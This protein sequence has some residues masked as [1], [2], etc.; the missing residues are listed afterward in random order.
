MV[1]VLHRAE[2][3]DRLA[4]GLAALLATPPAD[5]FAP[6]LVLVPAKGV[7]RWLSQRLSHRLGAAPGGTDGV[8]AGVEFRN[9]AALIAEISG[10]GDDDPW[11]AAALSWP[12]LEVLDGCLAEPWAAVLARH[13]GR[14]DEDRTDRAGRRYALARR[15]AALFTTY[16]VSRP[17]VVE[18]WLAGRD[19]DGLGDPVPADLAWQPEL[20]RRV[21][22]LVPGPAPPSGM[23][24]RWRG[25]AP[26]RPRPVCR[27]GS[28][29]SG[30][31]G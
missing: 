9:P 16:A 13:L 19:T 29:C 21:S 7:E 30:T 1:V 23:P 25:C 17:Q 14:D 2:R 20:L 18:D 31:P 8:C 27:S 28:R 3:T 5:P 22:A 15:L 10:V 12:M 4:E 24:P 6:D 11:S 26:T